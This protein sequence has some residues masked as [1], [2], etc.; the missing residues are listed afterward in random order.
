MKTA[1]IL[2]GSCPVATKLPPKRHRK[3]KRKYGITGIP[4]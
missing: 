2:L 4:V 3:P 1:S